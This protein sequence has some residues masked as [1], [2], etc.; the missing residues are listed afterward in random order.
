MSDAGEKTSFRNVNDEVHFIVEMYIRFPEGPPLPP[1]CSDVAVSM[2][3]G[4]LHRQ[5]P[6]I[7]GARLVRAMRRSPFFEKATAKL[8]AADAVFG[9]KA[10]AEFAANFGSQ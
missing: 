3:R 9:Q 7:A 5:Q 6:A 10:A 4:M 1:T 8:H 2:V